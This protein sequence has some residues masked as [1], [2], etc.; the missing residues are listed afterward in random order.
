VGAFGRPPLALAPTVPN[1]ARGTT[2]VRFTLPASAP[3]TLE[4]F[5]LQGRRI[6]TILDRQPLAAGVHE[7]PLRT[8]R[9]ESG[10]YLVRLESAGAVAARKFLVLR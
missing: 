4:L 7:H 8:D 3:V 9:L 6:A 10:L 5:D 2:L 1:P